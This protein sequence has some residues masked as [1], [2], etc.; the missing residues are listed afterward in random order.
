MISN[1]IKQSKEER[2]KVSRTA[3]KI[4]TAHIVWHWIECQE[5]AILN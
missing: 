4:Q 5:I 1:D 3:E 2:E